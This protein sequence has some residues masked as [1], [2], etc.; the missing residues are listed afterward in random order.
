M[1]FFT[2]YFQR[3]TILHFNLYLIFAGLLAVAN[4][5]T[6]QPGNLP[7]EKIAPGNTEFA[8]KF[9]RQ[10]ALEAH[11]KNIL[12]SPTIISMPLALLVLAAKS[13]TRSQLLS[14]LCFN[15]TDTSEQEIHR[16][17]R[18]LIQK[19]NS[20]EAEIQRSIGNTLFPNKKFK[21]R[22]KFLNNAKYFYQADVL[23]TNFEN[24]TEA[25]NQINNYIKEKTH[26]KITDIVKDLDT[27][28][29]LVII[30]FLY[31]RDYWESPFNSQNTREEDFF[32]DEQTTVKVPMMIKDSTFKTYY[33]ESLSCEVVQLPYKSGAVAFFILP[34]QGKLKQV[35]DGLNRDVLLKWMRSVRQQRI[36]LHLPKLMIRGRYDLI[37]ILSRM[38][39][40]ELFTDQ[41]DLSGITGK[42]EVKVTKAIHQAYLNVHEN[43]TEAAAVTFIEIGP[44]SL[45]PEI[46]LNHPFMFLIMDWLTEAILFLGKVADPTKN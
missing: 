3:N 19:L 28:A 12:F 17:F 7:Y 40:T 36:V 6:S 43:G 35:E 34:D 23:P 10:V 41:A 26:G 20:T 15:Q 16:G 27:R 25:E 42:P 33:D 2:G 24:A 46:K 4:C 30:S 37:E 9:Y 31:M 39:I 13:T 38:G 11:T 22:K 5:Q 8:F 44:T 21:L 18:H 45:P 1:S 32:V 14:G 29:I